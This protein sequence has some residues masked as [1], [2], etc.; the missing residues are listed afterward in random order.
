MK[1]EEMRDILL[2]LNKKWQLD[3]VTATSG[4]DSGTYGYCYDLRTA[5]ESEKFAYAETYLMIDWKFGGINF[6]KQFQDTEW[7]N[8]HYIID[9]K[10]SIATICNDLKYA[11]RNDYNLI[12][13]KSNDF[14][15]E[16]YK[17]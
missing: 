1:Y 13:P 16:I 15:I 7:F 6:D 4:D 11:L 2:N 8:I 5:E 10:L 17:K 9:D 14:C 12:P 3:Y